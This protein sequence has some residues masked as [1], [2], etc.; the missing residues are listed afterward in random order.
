MLVHQVSYIL[1]ITAKNQ[2]DFKFHQGLNS[3]EA[4]KPGSLYR[5]FITKS[6]HSIDIKNY[7]L[8]KKIYDN[9]SQFTNEIITNIDDFSLYI[10]IN[11]GKNV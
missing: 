2:L 4:F 6:F 5:D 3:W 10:P 8:Y 7:N 1:D 11:E 9:D